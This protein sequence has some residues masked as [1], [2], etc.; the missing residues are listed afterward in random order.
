MEGGGQVLRVAV[1]LSGIEYPLLPGEGA[2]PTPLRIMLDTRSVEVFA[3]GGR[4]AWSDGISF[5]SCGAGNCDVSVL[6]ATQAAD[7]STLAFGMG[8]IW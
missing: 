4:A 1:T 7:V 6:A 2:Q 8:S 3:H 5:A